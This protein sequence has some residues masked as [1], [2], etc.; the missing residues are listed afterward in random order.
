MLALPHLTLP[1]LRSGSKPRRAF[2][3]AGCAIIQH[4]VP[5][6]QSGRGC[7]NIYGRPPNLSNLEWKTC[8]F[9]CSKVSLVSF[10]NICDRIVYIVKF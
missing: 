10:I 4:R 8:D 6:A 2:L 1:P 9:N 7:I 5:V 3:A